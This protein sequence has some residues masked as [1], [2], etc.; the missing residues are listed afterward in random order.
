MKRFVFTCGDINGIGPEIA[1]KALNKLCSRNKTAQFI[2][3]IPENV[4][5]TTARL[6]R[7]IF[8]YK[9]VADL[10][11]TT[12]QKYQVSILVTRSFMQQLPFQK[13][14]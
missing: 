3:I 11:S 8:T 7:P 13:Q 5:R 14:L 1:L 10:E 2:L 4:F 12:N 9:K 6:V